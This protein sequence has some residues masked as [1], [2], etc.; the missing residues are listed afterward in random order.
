MK[1]QRLSLIALSFAALAAGNA[2]AADPT[3]RLQ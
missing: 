1:A 2:F 3:A